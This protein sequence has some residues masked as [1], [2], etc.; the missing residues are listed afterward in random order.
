MVEPQWLFCSCQPLWG[1]V[2]RRAAEYLMVVTIKKDTVD[3]VVFWQAIGPTG[4]PVTVT[5][6]VRATTTEKRADR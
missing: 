5:Q 2:Q 6:Y 4:S 1:T 3:R